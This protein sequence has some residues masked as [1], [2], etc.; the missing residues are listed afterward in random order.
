[1]LTTPSMAKSLFNDIV[2]PIKQ[3]ELISGAGHF[4]AFLQPELFLAKLLTYVRPLAYSSAR[5]WSTPLGT[6]C[7]SS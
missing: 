4:A 6:G 1:M 5:M 3:M 2:A 7:H